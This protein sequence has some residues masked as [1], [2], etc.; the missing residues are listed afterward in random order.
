MFRP[1]TITAVLNGWILG[2]GCQTVVFQ[3][4]DQ[5]VRELDAYLKDPA[6]TEA[7]FLKS[8][9]NHAHVGGPLQAEPANQWTAREREARDSVYPTAIHA[10]NEASTPRRG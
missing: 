5:L 9:V 6:G 4:R 10:G 7:R 8:S 3:D 2:V 1:I